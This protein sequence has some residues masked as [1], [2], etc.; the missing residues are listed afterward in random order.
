MLFLVMKKMKN[1]KIAIALIAAVGLVALTSGLVFAHYFTGPHN[2]LTDSLHE[3]I[4]EDWWTE[5]REHMEARWSGIED[6]QWFDDMLEYMEEHWSEVQNQ[7]W[8][9]E[10]VEYMED[11][12]YYH[13]G[14]RGYNSNYYD[15]RSYRG[16]GFG[17]LGW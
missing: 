13:Y 14:Y 16:R 10:M 6:E 17:C 5:I 4:N 9:E 1:T 8:F 3:S 2:P 11:K 15:H 7:S 12:G